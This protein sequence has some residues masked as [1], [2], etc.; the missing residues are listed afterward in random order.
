[1]ARV[2][3][4]L[5]TNVVIRYLNGR[6]ET[7]RERF[8]RETGDSIAVCSVVR[9]ELLYGAAKSSKPQQA[10]DTQERFLN[11][12]RSLPFDDAA[13]QA[14]GPIR[15]YLE[16]LGIPIGAH[17]LLIAAIAVAQRLTLV[18]HNVAEFQRIPQLAI[19]DWETR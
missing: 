9:A 12:F 7:L 19:E 16:R 15:A 4:L 13:A 6:S 10:F 11:R 8:A 1:M 3:F 18:T 17:D 2:K 14:Y 5:D